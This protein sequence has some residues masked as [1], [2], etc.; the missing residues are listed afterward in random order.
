MP[1]KTSSTATRGDEIPEHLVD[2]VARLEWLKTKIAERQLEADAKAKNRTQRKARINTTDPDSALQKAPKGYLQGYNGQLAVTPE[3]V[4]VAADLTADNND[5]AQ[6]KPMVTQ[7]MDNL[8][9]V[10][11]DDIGTVV[12]DA[13]YF[14]DTNTFLDLGPRLLIT[15]V[16]SRNL[17]NAVATREPVVIDP[18]AH[19]RWAEGVERAQQQ[20]DKRQRVIEG[21][22]AR[23]V[24]AQEVAQA[25]GVKIGYVYRLKWLFTRL[26]HLRL[27]PPPPPPRSPNA[28][29]V[30]LERLAEPGAVEVYRSR[31][32]TVEP[33]IGQ[34]KHVRGFRQFVHRG[35]EACRCE[36]IMMNTAHN[37]RKIWTT[38]GPT[39]RHALRALLPPTAQAAF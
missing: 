34:L 2:S 16:S 30:M 26:G 24:T 18:I 35:E 28:K 32:K 17:D 33:V 29:Q 8:E 9:A 13:G 14:D 22:V 20:A 7:A 3:Q 38:C 25:L 19:A 1:K 12:A 21:Y 31:A 37:L 10:G 23:R 11:A 5:N 36:F 39:L 15:P 6:L 27:P 4:I